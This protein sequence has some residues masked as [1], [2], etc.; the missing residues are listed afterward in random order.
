MDVVTQLEI[1]DVGRIV[2]SVSLHVTGAPMGLAAQLLM[3][4]VLLEAQ[5]DV[6][7]LVT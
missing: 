1:Q 2:R 4:S 5:A 6:A 3:V 7:T